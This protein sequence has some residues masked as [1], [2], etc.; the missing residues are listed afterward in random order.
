MLENNIVFELEMLE[1]M[2]L[3]SKNAGKLD[4]GNSGNPAIRIFFLVGI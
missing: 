1:N 2:P 4:S 3:F